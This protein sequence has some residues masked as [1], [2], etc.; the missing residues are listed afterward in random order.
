MSYEVLKKVGSFFGVEPIKRTFNVLPLTG[1][2]NTSPSSLTLSIDNLDTGKPAFQWKDGVVTLYKTVYNEETNE[3]ERK[4]VEFKTK[5][6]PALAGYQFGGG[7]TFFS[8]EKI[9]TN[10]CFRDP[11]YGEKLVKLPEIVKWIKFHPREALNRLW[12]IKITSGYSTESAIF[13]LRYLDPSVKVVFE[14]D[15]IKVYKNGNVVETA[16]LEYPVTGTLTKLVRIIAKG[17]ALFG[18]FPSDESVLDYF[19]PEEI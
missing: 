9:D 14:N 7:L 10:P 18:Y 4:I 3:Y 11:D 1:E 13:G 12:C 8:P 15:I 2:F 16:S 5:F 17:K 6:I 19:F